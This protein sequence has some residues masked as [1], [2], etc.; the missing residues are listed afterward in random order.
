MLSAARCYQV[1]ARCEQVGCSSRDRLHGIV[2][3]MRGWCAGRLQGVAGSG[4]CRLCCGRLRRFARFVK[5]AGCK[6]PLGAACSLAGYRTTPPGAGCVPVGGKPLSCPDFKV[7]VRWPA[8]HAGRGKAVRVPVLWAQDIKGSFPASTSLYGALNGFLIEIGLLGGAE[9][10]P[11]LWARPLS[12]RGYG[13]LPRV[14]CEAG[15]P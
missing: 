10:K 4:R 7:Q 5:L 12:A 13:Q 11:G 15:Q 8:G 6:V 1:V 3:G 9:S 2:R 14:C